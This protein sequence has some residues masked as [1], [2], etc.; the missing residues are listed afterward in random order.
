V[1]FG[2]ALQSA[3]PADRDAL[4]ADQL[5]TLRGEIR[6]ARVMPRRLKRLGSACIGAVLRDCRVLARGRLAIAGGDDLHWR[7]QRGF[8]PEEGVRGGVVLMRRIAGGYQTV[9]WS[10]EGY[11]WKPP[12]VVRQGDVT[13]VAIAGQRAGSGQGNADLL[14]RNDGARWSEVEIESWKVELARALP[15]GADIRRGVAYDVASLTAVSP[16]WSPSDADCCA[17][18]GI[19]RVRLALAADRLSLAGFD[20]EPPS[21]RS[22][23][24]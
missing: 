24:P 21:G 18:G 2:R 6:A 7:I 1:D 13:L 10:F 17:T 20:V 16:L 23:R 14:L 3:R 15:E 4:V 12:V 9:I 11:D 19:V 8:T 5:A 22:T